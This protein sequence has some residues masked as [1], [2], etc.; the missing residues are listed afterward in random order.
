MRP[1]LG[2]FV[3]IGVFEP[4]VTAGSAIAAAFAQMESI[5]R[6]MSFHDPASELSQL[7]GAGG[8]FVRLSAL[9][10]RALRLACALARESRGL[11]NCTV[12]GALVAR[13]R[14]PDHA[15]RPL[16]PSG[17]ADDIVIEGVR[18][19]LAR[20]VRV[21]LDG[22]AKG[23]AV[24]RA[25]ATLRAHGFRHAWVNA[26]GDVRVAGRYALPVRV[27]G[28]RIGFALANGAIASSGTNTGYDA[29]L[30]GEIVGPDLTPAIGTW[31]VAAQS[32]WRA[33]ALTKV[34][35]LARAAEREILLA[36][37]GGRLI[38]SEESVSRAA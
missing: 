34:A 27:R 16:L 3:E 9:T 1:A 22:L 36:Q 29:E 30:P 10:L 14:L 17:D 37:L 35:A 23:L 33:D 8:E 2:T 24:D 6:L 11:F 28:Q 5:A 18:A 26:G 12:G 19:R 31:T 20:P 13:G 38:D 32:A 4:G 7:N 25:I 15:R 21:T